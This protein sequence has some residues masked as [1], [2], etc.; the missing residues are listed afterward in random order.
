MENDSKEA[1]KA[2]TSSL[3]SDVTRIGTNFKLPEGTHQLLV[4]EKNA[5][6]ILIIEG[7][8]GANAGKKFALNLVA[9]TVTTS[10]GIMHTIEN[11]DKAGF[12]TLAFP[13]KFFIE[14]QCNGD[15]YITIN[16]KGYITDVVPAEIEENVVPAAQVRASSNKKKELAF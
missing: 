5:F 6:G 1:R 11:T 7:K 13:D 10:E 9:G 14:M 2:A 12:K 3:P 8:N 15:Y 16:D 4:A